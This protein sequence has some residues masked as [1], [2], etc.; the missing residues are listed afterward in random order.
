MVTYLSAV[1]IWF[2]DEL[3]PYSTVLLVAHATAI[4][5]TTVIKRF[6]TM[7]KLALVFYLLAVVKILGFDMEDFSVF[8]KVI[9]FMG[10]GVL[11]LVSAYQFQRFRERFL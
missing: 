11:L 10:I 1:D 4:L 9:A 6:S 3:G 7:L 8:Q 2:D 5:F